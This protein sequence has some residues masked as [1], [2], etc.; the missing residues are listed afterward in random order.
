MRALIATLLLCLA[1]CGNPAFAKPA[2]VQVAVTCTDW[3]CTQTAAP[4]RAQ[5]QGKAVAAARQA[6]PFGR[7]A[8]AHNLV[9]QARSYMGRTGPSL[10]LPA[11]LWCS[12]F[13]NMLTGGGTGSRLAK[14]WL[15]KPRVR[16]QIGA[17]A[18]M[19][20]GRRGGHVGVV[21]GFDEDGNPIIVSGNHGRRVGEGVYDRR[22]II[23]YVSPA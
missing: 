4:A 15:A 6:Q 3:I 23:A 13:L 9:E 7:T 10:G 11:R 12:D 14:S 19:S 8:S 21:S 2:R 5:K 17:I 1:S 18:V 16:P 20:R 22:R